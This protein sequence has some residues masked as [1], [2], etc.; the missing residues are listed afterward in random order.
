MLIQKRWIPWKQENTSNKYKLVLKG[1]ILWKEKTFQINKQA[2]K[3]HIKQMKIS[4]EKMDP[5]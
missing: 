4:S 1:G 3:N 5:L 2:K